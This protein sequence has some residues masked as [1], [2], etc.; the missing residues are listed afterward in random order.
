MAELLTRDIANEYRDRALA[1]K[2]DG[3][4]DIGKR[5]ELRIEL[6]NRCC[7]SELMA[8]NIVNGF[9]IDTY[10]AIEKKKELEREKE[11]RHED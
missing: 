8:L 4:Q 5:R 2:N 1:L 3:K 7:I 6:Q 9:H 10:V 11:E